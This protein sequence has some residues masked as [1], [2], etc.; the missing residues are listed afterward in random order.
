MILTWHSTIDSYISLKVFI[1]K[2]I[3]GGLDKVPRN[4]Q[5]KNSV[6]KHDNDSFI[7]QRT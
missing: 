3:E 2:K 5:E 7:T 6:G 4:V 1:V